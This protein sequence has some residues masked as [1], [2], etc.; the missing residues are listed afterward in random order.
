M[1]RCLTVILCVLLL[2]AGAALPSAASVPEVVDSGGLFTAEELSALRAAVHEAAAATG[3]GFSVVTYRSAGAYDSYIGEQYLREYG[4]SDT[5]DLVLLIITEENDQY[6]YDLYLYGKGSRRITQA[7][8]NAVLDAGS[9]YGPIKS[10]RVLDGA[11]SFL[12]LAAAEYNNRTYER[13]PYLKAL[14]AA[15]L[16]ALVI[17][18][19]AC[20]LVKVSYS[21]KRRSVDYPLDHFAKLELTGQSDRFTGSFVTQRVISHESGRTGG[22]HGHGSGGS[23]HGGGSGHAGG[24]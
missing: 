6:Y 13:S 21:T 7:E 10:G 22:G 23:R 9:V 11:S 15:L 17:G 18:V 12:S 1:K 3:C 4:L 16:I 14:P 20:I 5:D 8:A 24:R 19:A 2:A